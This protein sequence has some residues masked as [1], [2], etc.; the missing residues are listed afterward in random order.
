MPDSRFLIEVRIT[1]AQPLEADAQTVA[2]LTARALTDA[3]GGDDPVLLAT[4]TGTREAREDVFVEGWMASER[5]ALD[6]AGWRADLR[7]RINR[8]MGRS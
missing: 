6:N 4:A 2:D 5:N 8:A 3:L 7:G 1:H